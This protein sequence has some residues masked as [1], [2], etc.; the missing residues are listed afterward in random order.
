MTHTR[1]MPAAMIIAAFVVAAPI[2]AFA[3]EKDDSVKWTPII[4][5][6]AEAPPATGATYVG[7]KDFE[8][9]APAL[10]FKVDMTAFTGTAGNMVLTLYK[11]DR[12]TKKYRVLRMKRAGEKTVA[13]RVVPGKYKIEISVN[14]VKA[15]LSIDEGRPRE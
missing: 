8:T 6:L 5:I 11:L 4:K 1:T 2:A 7:S 3:D 12:P 13:M 15:T 14:N 10:R 9:E